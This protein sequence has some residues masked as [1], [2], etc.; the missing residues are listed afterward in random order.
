[1]AEVKATRDQ[2]RAQAAYAR[3]D[4]ALKKGEHAGYKSECMHLP[5]LI[6]QCGLCQALAFLDAKGAGGKRYFH[7]L[8]EDVA[9]VS[10][11]ADSR[12]KLTA[13]ARTAGVQE[14]QRMTAET[15][16]CAQWLKRYAEALLKD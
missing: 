8:L 11:L 14:Y 15:M 16:A 3:V 10:R 13:K 1:M 12:E 9:G 5:A 6:H 7:Q 2:E 4:A